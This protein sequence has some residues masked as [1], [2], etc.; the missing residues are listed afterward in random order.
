[1][2]TGMSEDNIAIRLKFL[3]EKLRYSPSQFADECKIPRPTFSQ[4][5]NGRNKK[6]SD[7]IIRQVHEAFPNVSINWLL[8]NE[9]DMLIGNPSLVHS[10][11]EDSEPSEMARAN[12][13]D[14]DSENFG[15]VNSLSKNITNDNPEFPSG[16]SAPKN[17]AKENPLNLDHNRPQEAI[18]EEVK[19]LLKNT[20]LLGEIAKLQPKSRKVVSVTIYYDDSTFETFKPIS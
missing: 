15:N 18:K 4:I 10:N 14:S 9:G 7:Q 16:S 3:I 8:F 13:I 6:I 20:E 17:D 12:N 11:E 19:Q 1:M 5:L 2:K